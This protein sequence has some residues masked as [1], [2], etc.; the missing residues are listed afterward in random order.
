MPISQ[1]ANPGKF[2]RFADRLMPWLGIAAIV[3]FSIGLYFA[4]YASPPD[5]QQGETVRIM[6]LHVPAAWM[7]LMLYV[8][9]AI[10]AGTGFVMRH[11]LADIFCIATAP[12]GA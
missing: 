5:Y 7:S 12:V 4:L 9:M 2:S 10:A 1:F 6:Y 3:A 11:T 8:M